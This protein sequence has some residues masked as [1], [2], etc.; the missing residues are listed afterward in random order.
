MSIADK[1]SRLQTAKN[2]IASA[3]RAKGGSVGDSDGFEEFPSAIQNLPAPFGVGHTVTLKCENAP[4]TTVYQDQSTYLTFIYADG[5]YEHVV[6]EHNDSVT[7]NN[8]ILVYR[9]SGQD[10]TGFD[11]ESL[12]KS[13]VEFIHKYEEFGLG[14]FVMIPTGDNAYAVAYG[15]YCLTG[16]TLILMADGTNGR[17]DSLSVGDKVLSYN[18]ATMKLEE[19]EITYSDSNEKKSHTEWDRWVFED[20][21]EVHTVHPHR[22]FNVDRQQMV[23]MDQWKLG[24]HAMTFDGRKVA[25]LSHETIKEEVRHYTIFTKNQN[26]FANGLLSGNRHTPALTF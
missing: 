15:F 11:L 17:I 3:I 9:D 2:N 5:T 6:I 8:V 14:P 20:G 19:D 24:E 4:E 21:F 10:N 12:V 1:I 18:P 23:Y 25:L 22:F 13:R 16:D 26:Y 7:R